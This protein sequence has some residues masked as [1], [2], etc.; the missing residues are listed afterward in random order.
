MVNTLEVK[1]A[2]GKTWLGALDKAFMPCCAKTAGKS[3]VFPALQWYH[4]GVAHSLK[5]GL[6]PA[7]DVDGTFG[8][9]RTVTRGEL[10]QALW[11]LAGKPEAAAPRAFADVPED[12]AARDAIAWA[13]E[14]GVMVG[15]SSSAFAPEAGLTREQ[16]ATALWRFARS[17]GL[18]T[19]AG[20]EPGGFPD[21]AAS[22]ISPARL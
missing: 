11:T 10:V 4:D 12:H 1:R 5:N 19:E 2:N 13:A 20:A 8:I 21:A 18:P 9:G 16:A 3:Y 6:L 17:Q 15:V 14:A 22:A 7:L